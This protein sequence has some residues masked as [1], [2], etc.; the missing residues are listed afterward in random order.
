MGK[1]YDLSGVT[2][3]DVRDWARGSNGYGITDESK[4]KMQNTLGVDSINDYDTEQLMKG[5]GK[6][7]YGLNLSRANAGLIGSASGSSA[8]GNSP[9]TGLAAANEAIQNAMKNKPEDFTYGSLDDDEDYKSYKDKLKSL[10]ESGAPERSEFMSIDD[11]DKYKTAKEAYDS[12]KAN[13]LGDY[14][15]KYDEQIN[16]LV[17]QIINRQKFS[18]D[19][20]NDDKYAAYKK[21]AE[22]SAR[23]AANNSMALGARMSGGYG[24]SYAQNAAAQA[25]AE[26]M[27]KVTDKIPEYEQLAYERDRTDRSDM[28]DNLSLLNQRESTD[29]S[30]YRDLVGDYYT[31]LNMLGADLDRASNLYTS[32]RNY[33]TTLED[34]KIN[35]YNNALY[36]AMQAMQNAQNRYE[37]DRN[38]NYGVNRDKVSDY[39]SMLDR[40][41]DERNYLYQLGRDDIADNRYDKE[42]AD[43]RSDIERSWQ[44]QL[45]RDKANDALTE[46]QYQDALKQQVFE[47]DLATKNYNL[48]EREQD[49]NE[50]YK[51][52][53]LANPN[54]SSSSSSGSRRSSSGSSGSSGSSY[55]SYASGGA[56]SASSNVMYSTSGGN[57][58]EKDIYN[59]AV[60][61][62]NEHPN[63]YLDDATVDNWGKI[64][65]N[66]TGRYATGLNVPLDGEAGLKFRAYLQKLGLRARDPDYGDSRR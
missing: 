10:E 54:T 23:V 48:S 65:N 11:Y 7:D 42:Y 17:D 18:Y 14:Q 37:S 41:Y 61:F 60:K 4:Q 28:L 2:I 36:Y 56:D 22:D 31:G 15:S 39:N 20:R 53:V 27:A 19:Y 32:D 34:A 59:A 55:G 58:S 35:D 64:K 30:R 29:Y 62:V 47:N 5:V 46:R 44:Y 40:L 52:Y 3:D 25:Y 33:H 43:N 16:S 50:W 45:D 8:S 38:F 66:S 21:S 51:K 13:K 49:F 6:L 57:V 63:V 24:N 12:A 9:L 1:K 26:Q